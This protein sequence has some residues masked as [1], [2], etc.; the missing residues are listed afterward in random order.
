MKSAMKLSRKF[1]QLTLAATLI[2]LANGCYRREQQK[3]QNPS[4]EPSPTVPASPASG[5]PQPATSPSPEVAPSQPSV[6]SQNPP[7]AVNS[8]SE[9]RHNPPSPSNENGNESRLDRS[10]PHPPENT[11]RNNSNNSID[12]V[13]KL[14]YSVG[15]IVYESA[16]EMRGDRGKMLTRYFNVNTNKQEEAEQTIEL[17]PSPHGILLLGSNPIDSET[18]KPHPTYSPDNFL[19][20]VNPDGSRISHTCD[21]AGNCSPVE[22]EY[23]GYN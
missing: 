6:S 23:L 4:L 11:P 1:A 14:Q 19:F 17:Q 20:R 16:L 2:L 8:P 15:G 12:G 13:W 9:P 5:N 22:I 3:V 10:V 18:Q 21:D 7:V